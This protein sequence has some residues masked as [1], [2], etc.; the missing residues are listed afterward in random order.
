LGA[1]FDKRCGSRK[2]QNSDNDP[3]RKPM[4][5]A[6]HNRVTLLGRLTRD[7]EIRSLDGG[8][9]VANFSVATTDTWRNRSGEPQERSQFHPVVIWNQAL[10]EATVPHLK[11][12]SRVLLEG[13]LDRASQL[14]HRSRHA[15]CLGGRAAALQRLDRHA[16]PRP[17]APDDRADAL[18]A[19][20]TSSEAPAIERRCT[21][22]H[23]H[24]FLVFV[25]SR[26]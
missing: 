15:L 21:R 18:T 17:R 7:P 10:I 26:C 16:R 12:G 4:P 2:E 14:R 20:G 13:A 5:E 25:K 6:T 11:K 8:D 24:Y 1:L 9:Q 3:G 23:A 19:N 22:P